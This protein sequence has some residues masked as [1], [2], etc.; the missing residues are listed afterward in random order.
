MIPIQVYANTQLGRNISYLIAPRPHTLYGFPMN[1]IERELLHR[2][3]TDRPFAEYITQRIDIGDFDDVV[4][5]RIYDG[6]VDLLY[7]NREVSYEVLSEYID[8]VDIL[9]N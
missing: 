2:I 3:I 9:S 7:Q 5:N 8:D 4:A 6:I 1:T